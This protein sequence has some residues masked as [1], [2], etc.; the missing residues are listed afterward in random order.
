LRGI[1]AW[2]RTGERLAMPGSTTRLIP[3]L[4]SASR[5]AKQGRGRSLR[6]RRPK[7]F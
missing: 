4:R 5:N 1:C 7:L 3:S 6:E 2:R